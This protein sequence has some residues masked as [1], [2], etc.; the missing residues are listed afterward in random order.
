MKPKSGPKSGRE[1]TAGNRRALQEL[2]VRDREIARLR[3]Q[4]EAAAQI[5]RVI[6]ASPS[7]P[8][9][10]FDM[11]V[12]RAVELCDG[13]FSGVFKFDGELV[14]L[15]AQQGLTPEGAEVYRRTF[16]RPA[17]RDSA[18][19]RAILSRT[20]AHIP[21]VESDPEYGLGALARA[22]TMR[23]IVAVPMLRDGE[24]IGGVVVWRSR[25]EPFDEEHIGLLQTFAE[26]ASIAVE[27]VRLFQALEARN[28]DVTDA[29]EQQTATSEILR[30]ISSSP[31][32]LQP[33]FDTILVN[34]RRLCGAS[35]AALFLFDGEYLTLGAQQ[36][37]S[38]EFAEFLR[39]F[40]YAP[41][42]ETATRRAA[43]ER[44]IVH[45]HDFATDSEYA[46]KEVPVHAT[47]G[48][49]TIISVPLLRDDTLVGVIT[50]WRREVKPFTDSQIELLKTFADQA[51]IAIENVRL[52]E[53]LQTRN[54][55]VTEALEQQ[56]A[57]AEILRVISGSPTDVQ[58]VFDTITRN[59]LELSDALFSA[60][61]RYDGELIHLVAHHNYTP[62]VLALE[63]RIFPM[64][65]N[66]EAAVGRAILNREVVHIEDA[67]EDPEYRSEIASTGGWRSMI[68]VPMFRGGTPLGVIWVA[69]AEAGPFRDNHIEIL[70]TFA[71]Q[72]VI[73]IENVRLFKELQTRNHEIS[74]ALEQQTATSDVLSVISSS[75]TDVQPVFDMI[76]RS[77][78]RL[79]EGEYS[80]VFRFD[81]E[82]IHLTSHDGPFGPESVE[83]F[84]ELYPMPPSRGH[85]IG[86]AI[87]TGAIAQIP[88]VEADS[89]Y[90]AFSIT[91]P[92]AAR[93]IVAVPMLREG[94]PIGGINV[95][96]A[97]SGNF[98]DSQ[99]ELLKTFA[100][101]AVIA[102]ENVRLFQALEAR[103]REITEA[104]EQQTATTEVLKVISRSTF[105]LQTVLETLLEN[106]ARLCHAT[107][108]VI[109]RYDGK[110][111]RN[112]GFYAATEEFIEYWK[113]S[114]VPVDRGSTLGRAAL[115]QRTVHIADVLED[116]DYTLTE[117]Q[118]QGGWRTTVAVPML[119]E[120]RLL[121]A[122][123][124]VRNEVK[125]FTDKQVELVTTFADQA[126][127]AI[128]NVRLLEELQ[129]RNRDLTETLEQQT[130]TSEILTVISS[131]P[132]DVQPV[133][134]T[135]ARNAVSLCDGFFCLV[136]RFDG[137]LLHLAAHHNMSPEG[138]RALEEVFPMQLNRA[139]TSA[140]AVLE[141]AVVHV[142]DLFADPAYPH[143]VAA[144]GGWR[145]M[146]AVPMLR[147]GRPIG[148]INVSRTQAV[149]FSEKQIGLVKT[150]A[151][152]AVIAIENVRLFQ[153]LETRN[154]EITEA[155][156]QQTATTEVLKIINRSTFDLEPVLETL[157]ENATKL[158]GAS[159]GTIFRPDGDV[160]RAAAVYGASAK[161]KEYLYNNPH[162]PGRGSVTGRVALQLETVH[163]P[164][165]PADPEYTF[166]SP[167]LVDQRTTL[168]VP[169]L[170]EGTL[171]GIITIWKEGEVSPFT[172]KQIELVETF[173]AQGVIAIENVRLL[174]ELQTRNEEISEALEQQ[175]ATAEILSV[176]STSPTDIQPV[177]DAVVKNAARF[178]G[179]SDAEI[180]QLDGEHFRAAAHHGPIPGPEGRRIPVARGSVAGRA[181]I[182]RCPVHV[183]DLQ[184]ETEEFPI[185]SALAREFGYRSA[186]AVPLLREGSAVGT[187]NLRRRQVDPFTEKQIGLLQTFAAQAVIAIENVRLF[188]EL[189]ARN[190]EITEALEQQTATTEVLQLISRSAF[191]LESVLGTLVENATR[192]CHAGWGIIYRFD[193]EVLRVAGYYGA[194]AEFMDYWTKIELRPGKGTAAQR[195]V[196]ERRTVHIPDV[197]E[198]PEYRETKGRE[199]GQ[200]RSIIAVPMLKENVM[201][202]VMAL[203]RNEVAPFTDR[204]IA[205]V[206]TFADQAAIA[207]ENVRLF[208]E[209][210]TR[211]REVTEALEQQTATSQILEVISSSPTDVQP[212]LDAVAENA[213]RV[214]GG[215]D[216][217]IYR[218]EDGE[219][220]LAA[221]HGPL[222]WMSEAMPYNRGSVLG[223]AVT[224]RQ[225]V[226]V[227]DLAAESDD[228]FPIGKDLQRR[229]G[230]RTNLATPLLREGTPIGVI[231]IR[232]MEVRPFTEKQIALLKTFA[233]QAVIAIE[234]ARLF[235]ELESRTRELTRSVE[236]LKALGEI[237]Q[238]I[239]STLDLEKVLETIVARAV[240]L[241]KADAGTIY[242]FDEVRQVFEPRANYGMSKELVDALRDS[243]LG[244]G[245]RHSGVGRAAAAR[246]AVQIPDISKEPEYAVPVLH[247]A[248]FRALLAVPL[249]REERIVGGLVVRRKVAGEFPEPIV[250]LLETF[251]TQSALAIQ[252]ARLFQQIQEKSHE[253]EVA[254]Q[255]KSQFVAN[256]SHEL[257]TP[258]N[259]IIGYS[260]M[261]EE[262]AQEIGEESFLPDLRNIQIA[263]KHL[264][265]L[266]N[267]IL[268]LSKIEAGKMELF[269]ERFDVQTL[270]QDVVATVQPLVEKNANTLEVSCAGDLG[271]MHA[272]LTKVRQALFNLLS[273]ACK[274][275]ERGTV[276][277]EAAHESVN[278]Q[279]WLRFRVRDTG[280]GMT[281]E[282]MGRLFQAFSQAD[283]STTRQ[284]GGTGLGLVI[285]RSFCQ[286]M[287]GDITV[288]SEHG[289]G[290]A[291][292]VR[293]PVEV[294]EGKSVQARE[295]EAPP[296]PVSIP[297][298]A[299]TVLVIDD[300]PAV[301]ALMQRFLNKEG[302]RMLAAVDGRQGLELAKAEHP[303]AITLDVLMPG[304]DGWAVLA[305]LKADAELADI[306]VIMISIA[307]ETH[308]GYALGVADYL[309]KPIEWKRLK[310]VLN[311]FR[312]A[313]ET[314]R[315]LVV[316][317]DTRTSRMLRKRLE[318][319]GW[320]VTEAENG[321]VALE[322]LA[323]GVPD[324][325]LLDLMM[326]EMDGFQ[327]LDRIRADERWR[328]I[329]VIVITAK[330]L[331]ADDRRRL[332]GY[333]EKILE[334]GTYSSEA[335]LHEVCHVV[336]S[337]VHPQESKA[338]EAP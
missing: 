262:E 168:G 69:R 7:D 250:D 146:L 287:G 53:Q 67:F 314:C 37:A 50:M 278:G 43:L 248:G 221:H 81:G 252:N 235:Q 184:A 132:T 265:G 283:A 328:A 206:T 42:R 291:F 318:K 135:I 58:P 162:R 30:V 303:D 281:Q 95:I 232:R 261:L 19:G 31:T 205:L 71:D 20:L 335:L 187:I 87:L 272:D 169:M 145:S 241:S 247:R 219:L 331:T 271:T 209:L 26:Q 29:L 327:L 160:F 47:E 289:K 230:H 9:P 326:P 260:E 10:V 322:R 89:E 203:L 114:E 234:N 201:I 246:T 302:L 105:D 329:P 57:T 304:M 229:F 21:D 297:E 138:L 11:I 286:M 5:L 90:K 34:A 251:A 155:L 3:A 197:L 269:L 199:I 83:A 249:L 268:D 116:P 202:G 41:S 193:G 72:A 208:Q 259:A 104:L 320:P 82:Q 4:R 300:D 175:T 321:R 99:L 315:V 226:H 191:D 109:H 128:E 56:T 127:I 210:E 190:K 238:T 290:S 102:V 49:R 266:I 28:R 317:D 59:A 306:P 298:G 152:Q 139:H 305:A 337:R 18:I 36:N 106:A 62:E 171:I 94:R 308:G 23:S 154:K 22:G 38:P 330:D 76:S 63:Q 311:H 277:L 324:V 182:D 173:A 216:A 236:E 215:Y 117:A 70:K 157:I 233:D 140:R 195:A 126:A 40:R 113:R 86:R 228:E 48:A 125:P 91:R 143:R 255:H 13:Q 174:Q 161:F 217:L 188:Q 338:T 65:P 198:D 92:V 176:I 124:L 130:A 6:S 112:A 172:Q 313:G 73:A 74:E 179:A 257:R 170:R 93:S 279:R 276:T 151:A 245:D 282:Q 85:A 243:R 178:C 66:R 299:P 244:L 149:P 213:A 165:V 167:E 55:E 316:E 25:P 141:G 148:T 207:I 122:M 80:A 24:P 35:F 224:D 181:L 46:A 334:K 220:H 134:D 307:D 118:R 274:F 332:N 225:T 164:D 333:V 153:E 133:F 137:E 166:A 237:G 194:S 101:Q 211:N 144:S 142:P 156:E 115:E 33:T 16:P 263:G 158:S 293:L 242:E 212:V 119:R 108:G 223:R 288:E 214:C 61:Y 204:Q 222:P 253:L 256:M 1:A 14:H 231:G 75:P 2:E 275:T 218:V 254:S 111:L 163:V 183:R 180:Y 309:T 185:G 131:S 189:Q 64:V 323:E 200:W 84:Q 292:T 159:K 310:A 129:T 294:A 27:N 15:Q 301:R 100:E 110:V 270:V 39:T 284:Y 103:N 264:L 78:R 68:A 107:W 8:Q 96:R 123:A 45:I 136:T 240:E 239:S 51:L 319:Q 285:S 98:P 60:V 44:R 295:E 54:R 12:G 186:L 312:P 88:D 177:L 296:R 196:L 227:H 336:R 258:L 147:E 17:A 325:M 280:I 273:N 77:A 267:E 79:C 120:G 150:F 52:F 32:D 192:L 121:G 97:K